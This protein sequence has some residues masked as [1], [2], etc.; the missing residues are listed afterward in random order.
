MII[1]LRFSNFYSFSEE[2]ELSFELGKKPSP[3]K[4]DIVVDSD[5]RLKKTIR[6]GTLK[7]KTSRHMTIL[8]SVFIRNDEML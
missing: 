8:L 5:R 7:K 4:Y 6:T 2:T 1:Q 3:S